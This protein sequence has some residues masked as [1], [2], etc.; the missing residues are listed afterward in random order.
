M[1]DLIVKT[2]THPNDLAG[3]TFSVVYDCKN[4]SLNL[5]VVTLMIID[6][7]STTQQRH[8]S[9]SLY[10]LTVRIISVAYSIVNIPVFITTSIV[11]V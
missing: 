7:V 8:C 2:Y 5:C 9:F 10:T 1:Y 3:F 4:Y 6:P 11:A